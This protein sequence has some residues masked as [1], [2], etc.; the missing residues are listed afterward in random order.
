VDD[1]A[2]T[3]ELPEELWDEDAIVLPNAAGEDW[4]L[5]D[6]LDIIEDVG[7]EV[8][9]DA[10]LEDI[11]GLWVEEL[12]IE[13]WDAAALLW[14]EV[15]GLGVKYCE[16]DE[17]KPRLL[18]NDGTLLYPV[19]EL[20]TLVDNV[21]LPRGAAEVDGLVVRTRL[22]DEEMAAEGTALLDPDAVDPPVDVAEVDELVTGKAE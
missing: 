10:P 12:A 5:E 7:D 1:T 11:A 15:V 22:E 9:C 21:E 2:G 17:D 4:L 3:W 16:E 6:E 19:C 18:V 13:L 8:A 20:F 14:D